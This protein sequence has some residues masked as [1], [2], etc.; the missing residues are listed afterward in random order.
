M[1]EIETQDEHLILT[2]NKWVTQ[3]GELNYLIILKELCGSKSTKLGGSLEVG[4]ILL[5]QF[6]ALGNI[7]HTFSNGGQA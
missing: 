2:P 6:K 7:G 4:Q 3:K 1:H 5:Q